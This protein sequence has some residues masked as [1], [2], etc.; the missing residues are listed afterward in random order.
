MCIRDRYDTG[1]YNIHAY[2]R[3]SAGMPYS[4]LKTGKIS[5]ASIDG[6]K[7]SI[8]NKDNNTGSFIARIS[9]I[10]SPAVISNVQVAVWSDINGQDD[11]K[12][13]SALKTGDEYLAYIYTSNHSY[14]NGVY[15]IHAY[16]TD[17]RGCLL[18]TSEYLQ[19]SYL[20]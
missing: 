20:M 19:Y 12:W 18:Y 10:S 5:V 16:A 15:Q 13:Y 11:L 14:D 2:S 9:G 7:V 17:K 4:C 3:S 1:Q 6:G 8:T